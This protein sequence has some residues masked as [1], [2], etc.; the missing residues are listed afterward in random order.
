MGLDV[1]FA[2]HFADRICDKTV[3]ETCTG[4]G[5]TTIALARMA[6]HVYSVEIDGNRML[7]AVRNAN[8]AGIVK[9]ITFI[10][11]DVF[12]VRIE[13]LAE[14][15]D[16][17]FIDHDWA[18]SSENRRF[19]ASTRRPLSDMILS[20]VVRFTKKMILIQPPY[21]DESAFRG[22][23]NSMGFI[24]EIWLRRS[25]TRNSE[26]K[27]TKECRLKMDWRQRDVH[28]NRTAGKREEQKRR[29]SH[30]DRTATTQGSP[31]AGPRKARF[32]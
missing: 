5:S 31:E 8:I 11:S 2:N 21:I 25:A 16:A 3:L 28:S 6:K 12:D 1:R 15:I 20:H 7:V 29:H 13:G 23:M 9:K 18:D 32:L 14:T 17:A 22:I 30:R 4:G 26:S 24:L 19:T 27:R 10:N